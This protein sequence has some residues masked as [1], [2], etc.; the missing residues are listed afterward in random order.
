[1]ADETFE[2][3]A[4]FE[5][6][7]RAARA[8]ARGKRRREPVAR[9][10]ADLEPNLL[11]I[12]RDLLERTYVPGAHLAK[13]IR[14]PKPRVISLAPFRDRVVNHAL[15]DVIEPVL[16]RAMTADTYACRRGKGAHAA[17][18]RACRFLERHRYYLKADVVKFFPSV[19]HDILLDLLRRRLRSPGALW[20]AET[21][22]RSGGA[23]ETTH[24]HFP[25][26]DLFSP[27]ARGTGLPIG[28][29]TSQLFANL[30]LDPIDH[31]IRETWRVPGYV[32]YADDLL[33][34]ADDR[35]LLDDVRRR[36]EEALWGLR[37]RL[38]E[39]KTVVRAA[40]EGVTFLG[41]RCL[42]GKDGRAYRRLTASAVKRA[43]RRMRKLRHAYA[44]GAVEL[45]DV[46][47]S[48]VA[49]L[50]HARHG[51]CRRLLDDLTASW[52]L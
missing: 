50:A 23:G 21:I 19:D 40:R 38:H 26:D 14:D 34:F 20:L 2:R 17:L 13:P 9:F 12:R 44:R 4:S 41:F 25:G 33:L 6:L 43:K 11:A 28:N 52:S 45:P 30:Y 49:W 39:G 5:N 47:A 1:V 46:K 24:F 29:L 15:C 32:R 3:I 27:L 51:D 42:L 37:L 31:A 7:L 35:G 18:D 16:D 36:L 48:L 10:L 22:V 8:A